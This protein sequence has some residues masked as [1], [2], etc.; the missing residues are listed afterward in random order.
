MGE[1]RFAHYF[2]CR[3]N[4]HVSQEKSWVF[5][6]IEVLIKKEQKFSCECLNWAWCHIYS[7]WKLSYQDYH[8][9]KNI[10]LHDINIHNTLYQI[11]R[12]RQKLL[13]SSCKLKIAIF[14]NLVV[15]VWEYCWIKLLIFEIALQDYFLVICFCCE[16]WSIWQQKG[17]NAPYS[18]TVFKNFC[19]T[20]Y[21]LLSKWSVSFLFMHLWQDFR[22][23][24]CSKFS[25]LLFL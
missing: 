3:I 15:F 11:Y 9:T 22:I 16:Q 14:L 6:N 18:K 5:L 4:C 10:M 8:Q 17:N 20:L 24:Q 2:S 25:W 1:F 19:L 13:Y 23:V 21:M 12:V 7:R